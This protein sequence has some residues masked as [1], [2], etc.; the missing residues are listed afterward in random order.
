M[1]QDK[2]YTFLRVN[3]SGEIPC[4]MIRIVDD[5]HDLGL[6]D[7]IRQHAHFR[8]E[9]GYHTYTLYNV[10]GKR[11]KYEIY[12]AG[13]GL[14]EKLQPNHRINGMLANSMYLPSGAPDEKC[15]QFI[16][17]QEWGCNWFVGDVLIRLKKNQTLPDVS[18]CGNI[19][20]DTTRD[21]LYGNRI[22]DIVPQRYKN[23]HNDWLFRASLGWTQP[24]GQA[25]E[26]YSYPYFCGD[27]RTLTE[28]YIEH[29]KE[30]FE[31]SQYVGQPMFDVDGIL[32]DM[33]KYMA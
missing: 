17:K 21:Y 12:Y 4:D 30:L 28:E 8:G 2:E 33:R 18:R 29:V 15:R 11:A 7:Q 9:V 27:S 23:K 14:N 10:E 24:F 25:P 6:Y 20:Q 22:N 31:S 16:L 26:Q 1:P 19:I 5:D 3:H 13:N 32:E